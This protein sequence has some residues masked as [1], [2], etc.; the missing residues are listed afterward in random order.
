MAIP[1]LGLLRHGPAVKAAIDGLTKT[2]GAYTSDQ[3]WYNFFKAL[4]AL[5]TVFGVAGVKL[6]TDADITALSGAMVIVVPAF[7]TLL[8]GLLN[9]LLRVRKQDSKAVLEVRKEQAE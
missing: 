1:W 2:P 7:L 4:I 9:L 5:L 3:N 6:F 8:D